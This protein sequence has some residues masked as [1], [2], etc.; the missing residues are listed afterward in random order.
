MAYALVSV[1]IPSI[2]GQTPWSIDLIFLWLIGGDYRKVHFDDQLGCSSKMAA[3]LDFG[4][5]RLQDKHG[6]LFRFL[7]GSL[8]AA[9]GTFISMIGSAAHP[10]AAILDLVS[11]YPTT[12]A[13][14]DS[15]D[16][17]VAYWGLEG[18]FQ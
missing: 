5:R 16:F 4:F 7:C 3:I 10:R 14:V 2:I 6:R 11:V 15:S 12:N 17:S 18:S 13:W 1:N 9:R 8:G